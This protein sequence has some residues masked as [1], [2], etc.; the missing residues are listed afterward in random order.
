MCDVRVQGE[1]E[2]EQVEGSQLVSQ[3][4]NVQRGGVGHVLCSVGGPHRT[5]APHAQGCRFAVC[6]VA[7]AL[8]ERIYIRQLTRLAVAQE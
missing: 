4:V 3:S 7:A 1:V 2:V 5:A 6:S 8:S